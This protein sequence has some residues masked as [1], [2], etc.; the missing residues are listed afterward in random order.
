MAFCIFIVSTVVASTAWGYRV[1]SSADSQKTPVYANVYD[2]DDSKATAVVNTLLFAGGAY[3][4]GIQ[5]FDE[6]WSYGGNRTCCRTGIYQ[7]PVPMKHPVHKFYKQVH[8]GSTTAS[9][10]DFH[11]MLK[12]LIDGGKWRG[13]D[14]DVLNHNCV[15]FSKALLA[16]FPEKIQLPY[17]MERL[18]NIGSVILPAIGSV[19]GALPKSSTPISQ[20]SAVVSNPIQAKSHQ[21]FAYLACATMP[22]FHNQC[23][24]LHLD[25]HWFS[26]ACQ[27]GYSC[28]ESQQIGTAQCVPTARFGPGP[29][30]HLFDNN[31][32][33]ACHREEGQPQTYRL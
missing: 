32:N 12:S 1:A 14:Y 6:E 18:M 2:L 21:E 8:V 3:H 15:S 9:V 27:F 23:G 31:V 10:D 7:M 16:A 13:I 19:L 17:W 33:G 28:H 22:Q 20:S 24:S 11:T 30:A 26:V 29:Q 25:G 5:A 4:V